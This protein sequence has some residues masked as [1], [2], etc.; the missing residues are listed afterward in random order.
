[1]E[2]LY[3]YESEFE[4]M[5]HITSFRIRPDEIQIGYRAFTDTSVF[6]L[7]PLKHSKVT[8]IHTSAF[9]GCDLLTLTDLPPDLCE[10]GCDAFARNHKIPN[11]LGLPESCDVHE[12]A[13]GKG[14]REED[15]C[16]LLLAKA[17]ILGFGG[18]NPINEWVQYVLSA[19]STSI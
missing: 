4:G 9:A 13:F 17:Q 1:M 2:V 18:S 5:R 3:D 15:Q 14:L 7:A 10:V 8:S 19:P 16:E 6:S 11:L 12:L